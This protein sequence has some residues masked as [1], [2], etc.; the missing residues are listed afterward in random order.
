[1]SSSFRVDSRAPLMTHPPLSP[2][3]RACGEFLGWVTRRVASRAVET[4]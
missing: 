3:A 1:M 4:E 2:R